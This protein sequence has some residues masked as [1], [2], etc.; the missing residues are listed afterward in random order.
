MKEQLYLTSLYDMYG[1]LLTDKQQEYFEDYYFNNLSL[2]EIGDNNSIS[3]SAIS[4]ALKEIEVK[5]NNYEDKLML[6]S[7]IKEINVLLDNTIYQ[8]KVNEIINR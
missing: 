3:R 6:V 4:K 1:S 5:L 7:K 2:S 8:D